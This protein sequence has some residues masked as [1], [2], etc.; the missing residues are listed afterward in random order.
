MRL[1]MSLPDQYWDAVGHFITQHLKPGE[2]IVAPPEFKTAFAN[3]LPYHMLSYYHRIDFHWAVIHKDSI[4]DLDRS[5][6]IDITEKCIPVFA[7]EVFVVFSTNDEIPVFTPDSPHLLAFYNY[8]KSGSNRAPSFL[9]GVLAPKTWI[10]NQLT[11]RYAPQ[12][13]NWTS[14]VLKSYKEN[15]IIKTDRSVKIGNMIHTSRAE[16]EQAC[17]SRCQSAY[18]G[19]RTVLCRVLGQYLLYADAEDIGITPHMCLD[20]FW[21]SWITYVMAQTVRS[22]WYCV[23]I[24]ANHGYYSLL[25]AAC[26]GASG[27][28]L[29]I[30]PNPRL[31]SLLERTL[32]VNGFQTYSQVLQKAVSDT[33]MNNVNLI[34]PR[35]R[36]INAT[37]CGTAAEGDEI[38]EVE[39]VTL[40]EITQDWPRVDFV[41]IDAEGAEEAI[42]RG[43]HA[44]ARRNPGLTIIMEFNCARYTD[45]Q[46]FLQNIQAAGF[47]LQ[48]IDYDANIKDLTIQQCLNERPAEDWMLFLQQKK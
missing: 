14:K 46:A 44:T 32:E 21:E 33:P 9:S 11:R 31:G 10:R 41:K 1:Y 45:A 43:M 26:T 29:A 6:L 4:K 36:G 19:N 28:V 3:V 48:H 30:E 13:G 23:D 8:L 12:G 15:K 37:I 40:D 7:N 27:R 39:T 20:G 25:M 24:G 2:R 22:G 17:R 35:Q 18:L 16:L 47:S 38:L 5:I 34:I 42:F